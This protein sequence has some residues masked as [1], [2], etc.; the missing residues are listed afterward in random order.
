MNNGF[1][2]TISHILTPI[3]HV[4]FVDVLEFTPSTPEHLVM[5]TN[6]SSQR[7]CLN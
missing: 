3:E 4:C 1:I 2:C 6:N 5:A 7:Q